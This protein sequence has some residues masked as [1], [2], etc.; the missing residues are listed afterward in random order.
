MSKVAKILDMN[1]GRNQLFQLLKGS[2]VLRHNNEP[3]QKYVDN[4]YFRVIEQKYVKADGDINMN[5]K[6]LVYQKGLDFIEK[7]ISN[8]N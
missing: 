1:L 5:I 8:N 4:G 2:K 7:L 3:Y 6:T